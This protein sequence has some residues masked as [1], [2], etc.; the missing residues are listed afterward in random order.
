M[1]DG[2][3]EFEVVG[4]AGNAAEAIERASA[5]RPDVALLDISMPGTSGIDIVGPLREAAP[6]CRV[7]MLSQHHEQS[8]VE[9]ALQAGAS[10][11]LSKT[12][13][14]GELV[15]AL[16][17]VQE[18]SPAA[19]DDL[20]R[21]PSCEHLTRREREVLARISAGDS[22]RCVAAELGISVR[23]A[24]AHRANLMRKTHCS[25]VTELVRYAI[26]IGVIMP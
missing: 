7:L 15:E 25:N 19:S 17:A 20:D 26:R 24:E 8:C 12:A 23:T 4:E 13:S 11:F 21:K 14:S 5:L 18:G 22:C 6:N 3:S 16:H 10:G 2:N 9:A 1:L